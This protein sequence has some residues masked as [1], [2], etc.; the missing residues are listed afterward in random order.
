MAQLQSG[1]PAPSFTLY[2]ADRKPVSLSDY[3]TGKVVIYFYP[4]ALTPGCTLEAVDFTAHLDTFRVAGYDIVGISPD[5]PEQLARFRSAE[6]LAV[7]LLADPDKKTI[8]AYGAWGEKMIY[9]KRLEG[10]IR[11]TFL[12]NVDAQ[13]AGSI[14]N[15]WYNIRATGHVKR[16]AAKL[17]IVL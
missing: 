14:E 15:A 17:G 2:D 7:T 11:S 6:N 12:V 3:A 5:T 1:S 16:L 10:I 9:G 8:T 13:G 4:A